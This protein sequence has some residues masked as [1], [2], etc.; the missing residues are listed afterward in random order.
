MYHYNPTNADISGR[1]GG[2]LRH[3]EDEI[4]GFQRVLDDLFE[5]DGSTKDKKWEI[6]EVVGQWWRPNFETSL[7][8]YLPAHVTRPKEVK[9]QYIIPLPQNSEYSQTPLGDRRART[10]Y[11]SNPCA[12]IIAVPKNLK[13]LA[14]PLYELYENAQ[15]YGPQLA[16]L[17]HYLARYRFEYVNDKGEV[18]AQTPGLA[19]QPGQ[20]LTRDDPRYFRGNTTTTTADTAMDGEADTNGDTNGQNGNHDE[21]Q[22][23]EVE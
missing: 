1:P 17:P 13:F 22:M 8:P 5:P 7:Y 4:E 6:G 14:I 3:D 23:D 2:W 12:E 11:A 18:V 10:D 19:P 9:K 21:Y 15:V 20:R 16:A